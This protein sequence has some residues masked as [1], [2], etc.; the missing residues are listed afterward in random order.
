M[1]NIIATSQLVICHCGIGTV[2]HAIE[3]AIPMVLLPTQTEQSMLARQLCQID[4]AISIPKAASSN[5]L[6]NTV[7]AAIKNAE[8]IKNNI[9]IQRSKYWD[10]GLIWNKDL[11]AYLKKFF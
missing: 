3:H 7:N 1:S 11:V 8:M 4:V 6:V 9:R 2:S 5:Q 10:N